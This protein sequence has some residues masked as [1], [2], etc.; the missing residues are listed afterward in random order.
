MRARK[1]TAVSRAAGYLTQVIEGGPNPG[2]PADEVALVTGSTA[3]LGRVIAARLAADG[4]GVI[5]TGRDAERGEAVAYEVGGTFVPAVL[6]SHQPSADIP[7]WL[8]GFVRGD[9]GAQPEPV[10]CW[11]H[12]QSPPCPTNKICSTSSATASP[13]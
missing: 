6:E 4:A 8:R 9:K 7:F 1:L 2:R 3:G 12:V 10:I 11:G 13:G 5:V